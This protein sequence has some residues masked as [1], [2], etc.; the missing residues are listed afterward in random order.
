MERRLT[1]T[2]LTKQPMVQP[3]KQPTNEPSCVQ[4]RTGIYVK[5]TNVFVFLPENDTTVELPGHVL[6]VDKDEPRT[7]SPSQNPRNEHSN[8]S[9]S[10]HEVI[11]AET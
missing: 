2:Y 1:W 4:Y 3:T 8:P 10:K 11:R 6:V 9:S 5:K 7:P